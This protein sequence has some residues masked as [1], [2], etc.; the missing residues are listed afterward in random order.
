MNVFPLIPLEHP[1][2]SS[3][4]TVPASVYE[5]IMA[6]ES[7][8]DQASWHAPEGTAGDP[9]IADYYGADYDIVFDQLRQR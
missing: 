7:N 1:S 5:A 2:G 3:Q 6:K 4:T 9:L 8:Y